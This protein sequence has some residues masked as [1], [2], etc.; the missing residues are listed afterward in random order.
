L[1]FYRKGILPLLDD[2]ETVLFDNMVNRVNKL[3][4]AAAQSK[5][6]LM[7]DAEHTYMQPAIDHFV[8]NLQRKH[9]VVFPSIFN[10]Y[11]V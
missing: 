1:I 7:I 4:E 6:R 8:L 3:A 11:Q 5:V 2:K 10:T 9:N